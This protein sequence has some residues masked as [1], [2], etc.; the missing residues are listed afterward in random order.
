MKKAFY[1][2]SFLAAIAIFFACDSQKMS[3]SDGEIETELDSVCYAIGIDI[4]TN[5]QKSGF[6]EI[7]AGAIAM[8]FRDVFEDNELLMNQTEAQTLVRE[9]FDKIRL[10]MKESNLEEANEFLEENKEKEGVVTTES[11]LQY[12]VVEEGTG[13]KPGLTDK[14]K[15]YYKG[16]LIDGTPFDSTKNAPATFRVNGV[17]KGW[18]EAL[19][20]MPEGAKWKLFIH[21]DLAYGENPRP[22]GVIEPNHALIFEIELVEIT[23]E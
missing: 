1:S 11:G 17:V 7:N 19:Q 10:A 9:Y 2:V 15:V 21:P 6:E 3:T 12:K 22:G 8:G 20:M 4:A 23:E 13:E 5:I 18:T 14:V 16:T